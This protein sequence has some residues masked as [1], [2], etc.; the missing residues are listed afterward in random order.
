LV[1]AWIMRANIEMLPVYL[2]FE[3]TVYKKINPLS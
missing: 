2:L 3:K 1:L